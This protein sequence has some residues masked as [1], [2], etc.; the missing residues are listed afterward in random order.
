M[1]ALE[2]HAAQTAPL[3]WHLRGNWAPV[4][5]ELTVADLRVD[6]GP[7]T[8]GGEELRGGTEHH[9]VTD[10]RDP[11]IVG[12]QRHIGRIDDRHIAFANAAGDADFD[13]AYLHQQV[14]A[15]L[16][17]LTLMGGY[18]DHGPQASSVTPKLAVVVTAP[19][20]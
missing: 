15:H 16:E 1:T 7:G 17:A 13:L 9:R 20:T 18:A 11:T 14:A 2:D 3:P 19:L 4:Q 6:E 8:E 12:D 10:H 5:D